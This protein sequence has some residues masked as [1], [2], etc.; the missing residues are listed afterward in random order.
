[1]AVKNNKKSQD[2]RIVIFVV[3]G[4][5]EQRRFEYLVR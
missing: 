5:G 4:V 3:H 2:E 1:M